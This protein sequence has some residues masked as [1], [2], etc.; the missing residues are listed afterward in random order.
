[1]RRS[2]RRCT[3]AAA[4]LLLTI[5]ASALPGAPGVQA[6]GTINV[7]TTQDA[8]KLSGS[9]ASCQ[10]TLMGN[11]CTLRAALQTTASLGFLIPPPYTI[12]VPAGTYTLTVAGPNDDAGASGDLDIA[13]D[14]VVISG[15]GAA[16]TTINGGALDRVFDVRPGVTATISGLTVTNGKPPAND[17]GGG[18]RV[19]AGASLILTDA[20]ISGNAADF[21]GGILN[22]GTATLTNVTVSNNNALTN[23]SSGGGILNMGTATLS[24]VTVSNN[25][26]N[27]NG[28]G[29][30]AYTGALAA[31][32]ST[33]SGN[34][35]PNGGGAYI[36]S[37]AALSLSSSVVRDNTAQGGG[38]IQNNGGTLVLTDTT[39]RSNTTTISGG[40][41]HL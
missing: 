28:G 24:N 1:M 37:G 30:V 40:G 17:G 2:L 19:V 32:G 16:T 36:D 22:G 25:A 12:V 31:T 6:A 26:A 29:I 41:R 33:L 38:G 23:I 9:N 10:S 3:V 13:T 18:I 27:G 39:V 20:V 21:G 8:P 4:A 5:L 7:T 14:G 34:S 15:A 11:P 35:A